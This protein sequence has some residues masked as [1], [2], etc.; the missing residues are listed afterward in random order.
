MDI[1]QIGGIDAI[2]H[3]AGAGI[4]D[5]RWTSARRREILE[6][7]VSGTSTLARW[8]STST[9]APKIFLSGSAIGLYGN[10]GDDV[11]TEESGPGSG[12]LADVCREW[13]A[14][15]RAVS[16]DRVRLATLRT[17]IV[18]SP[19]GGALKKQLPLF[20]LGLGGRLGD[21]Q[22]WMSPISLRDT[23]GA[24]IHLVE[25]DGV[26]PINLVAPEPARNVEVTQ[27]IARAVRRPALFPVPRMALA[28]A[29]GAE[30]ADEMLMTSQRIIPQ[31]LLRIGY[32]FADPTVSH[33][34]E[35]ATSSAA[36]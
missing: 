4:A 13:E 17:G 11:L 31:Q 12:F 19:L 24:I 10:R 22:Q 29:L 33:I 8:M 6:S 7:R 23:V 35:W 15:A 18:M 30:C 1:D 5:R 25:N 3:L 21:G 9:D 26:G 20:R 32:Q 2:V 28:V 34:M 14:A 27:A 36:Q 16:D